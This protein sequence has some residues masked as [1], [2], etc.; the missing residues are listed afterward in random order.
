KRAIERHLVFPISSLLA[1][2]QIRLGDLITI[3]CSPTSSK[4]SFFR[5]EEAAVVGAG[6]GAAASWTMSAAAAPAV[7]TPAAV[8]GLLTQ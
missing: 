3:D 8:A 6:K 7:A 1:T 5:D 4:L 2:G